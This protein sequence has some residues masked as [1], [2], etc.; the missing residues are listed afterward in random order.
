MP[1]LEER[2]TESREE[3]NLRLEAKTL[4]MGITYTF[5]QYLEQME[6]YLLQLEKRVR[7]L[8]AQNGINPI[9]DD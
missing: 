2:S 9:D 4:E 6:T 7:T 8:E 5:A 1:T 3:L